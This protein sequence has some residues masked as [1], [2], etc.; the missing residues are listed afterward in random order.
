[1]KL[2]ISLLLMSTAWG[3]LQTNSIIV[4]ASRTLPA[5]PDQAT[6]GVQVYSGFGPSL[7]DIVEAVSS[8]GVSASD[9][10]GF[11]F[12]NNLPPNT[13]VE[14]DFSFT[15]PLSALGGAINA[16]SSLQANHSNGLVVSF[17][18]QGASTSVAG[19]PACV[20]TDLVADATAEAQAL[21]DAANLR[22]GPVLA[23]SDQGGLATPFFVFASG[24]FLTVGRIDFLP[25]TLPS[26]CVATV[27]FGIVRL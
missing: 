25:S 15:V 16:L 18:F 9:F 21:A 14:W 20:I 23:V 17:S 12:L 8:A 22:L 2:C 3:Q 24:A 5:V 11:G 6:F 10:T 4:A 27:K 13:S 19:Q 7:S 1:M 26:T